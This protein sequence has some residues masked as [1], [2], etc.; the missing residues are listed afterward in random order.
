MPKLVVLYVI[1]NK[2]DVLSG[3]GKHVFNH[4]GNIRLMSLVK[5]NLFNRHDCPKILKPEVAEKIYNS[6]CSENHNY[7]MDSPGRFLRAI[8]SNGSDEHNKIWL[9]L[10]KKNAILKIRQA[11]RDYELRDTKRRQLLSDHTKCILSL[12]IE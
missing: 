10:D 5:Q 4:P 12:K 6:I 7:A 11:M 2:N 3:R 9:E 1:P 8:S